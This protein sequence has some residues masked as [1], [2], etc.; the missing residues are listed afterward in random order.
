MFVA[1]IIYFEHFTSTICILILFIPLYRR[2]REDG[3]LSPEH[4]GGSYLWIN[5]L[6][7]CVCPCWCICERL[8]SDERCEY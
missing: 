6:K 3:D 4:L 5:Y 7:S 2:L 8:H 1:G